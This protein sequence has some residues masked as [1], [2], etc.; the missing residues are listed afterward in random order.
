M[1]NR[2]NGFPILDKGFFNIK[3]KEGKMTG[4]GGYDFIYNNY[5]NGWDYQYKNYEKEK[6]DLEELAEGKTVFF[7]S[8]HLRQ[9]SSL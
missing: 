7:I 8:M 5:F 1:N 4:Y 9:L 2:N 3:C 6:E